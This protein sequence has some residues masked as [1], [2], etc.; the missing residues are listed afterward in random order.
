M[1]K[2]YYM[3]AVLSLIAAVSA[4]KCYEHTPVVGK[5]EKSCT[6]DFC[7]YL[8]NTDTDKAAGG[9]GN[10]G[11]AFGLIY[12]ANFK[13]NKDTCK[14]AKIDVKSVSTKF[15]GCGCKTDLC[16]HASVLSGAN[17]I[18]YSLTLTSLISFLY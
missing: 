7:Y 17:I 13:D 3:V 16:N 9:C 6:S 1:P 11:S 12:D 4:L 15:D 5:T 8:K 18:L 14:T 2:L 10:D